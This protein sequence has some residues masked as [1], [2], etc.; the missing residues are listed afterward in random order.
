MNEIERGI[1]RMR[2]VSNVHKD[3][4]NLS[5]LYCGGEMNFIGY[6]EDE[7]EKW[8]VECECSKCGECETFEELF[9]ISSLNATEENEC[10]ETEKY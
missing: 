8:F 3:G 1:N 2:K 4:I 9:F 6:F 10:K 7:E 5:C